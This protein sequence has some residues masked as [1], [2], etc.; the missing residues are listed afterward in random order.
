MASSILHFGEELSQRFPILRNAGYSV[1]R[2]GTFLEFRDALQSGMEHDAISL[3]DL[4]EDASPLAVL[5]ARTHSPAPVILFRTRNLIA[6]PGGCEPAGTPALA[7]ADFDLVVP[8]FASARAWVSD[9]ASLITRSRAIVHQSQRFRE[10]S[11]LVR[12][13]AQAAREKFRAERERGAVE[14]ARNTV[15]AIGWPTLIDRFLH[16]ANCGAEFVFSA[17]E[18]LFFVERGFVNDP[19]R[20]KKC[21]AEHRTG[22]PWTRHGTTITCAECGVLTKVPFKPNRG[23][24]VLCRACF[25]RR[26]TA[27]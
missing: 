18:Q 8:P 13:E 4:E 16:C 24:P 21:R 20:C 9:L 3:S 15:P 12:R 17:A 1:H 23:L 2:C 5:A 6:L 10:Q 25:Q 27:G 19:R 14:R 26:R 11:A 7:E 22:V